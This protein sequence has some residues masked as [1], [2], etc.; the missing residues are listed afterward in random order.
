[1][2]T[3]ELNRTETTLLYSRGEFIYLD[4][5]ARAGGGH[6]AYSHS[7][8]HPLDRGAYIALRHAQRWY[9]ALDEGRLSAPPPG[10]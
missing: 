7:L 6:V 3:I 9:K 1:M 5:W 8:I 10:W 4:V 2:K